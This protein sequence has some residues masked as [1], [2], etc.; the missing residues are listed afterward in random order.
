MVNFWLFVP[1]PKNFIQIL[2]R[3]YFKNSTVLYPVR[4]LYLQLLEPK[5]LV[6]APIST[7]FGTSVN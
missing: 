7:E 4:K 5:P 1:I 6:F 3:S 2:R